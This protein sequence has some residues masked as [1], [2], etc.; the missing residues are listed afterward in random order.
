MLF[1]KMFCFTHLTDIAV[2]LRS[3]SL[4]LIPVMCETQS[5]S[6]CADLDVRQL[7]KISHGYSENETE[8]QYKLRRQKSH[9]DK[10]NRSPFKYFFTRTS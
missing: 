10:R 7:A 5:N 4:F 9:I 6:V 2:V 3:V 1:F 8:P